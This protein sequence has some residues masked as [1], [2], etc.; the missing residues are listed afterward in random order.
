[1][2]IDRRRPPD[3]PPR[4]NA[5]HAV[6]AASTGSRSWRLAAATVAAFA[7]AAIV[8]ASTRPHAPPAEA[9]GATPRPTDEAR[10]PAPAAAV[11][12]DYAGLAGEAR[13]LGAWI[14]GHH[15]ERPQ[16]TALAA[17]IAAEE[18]DLDT[19]ATLWR[20]RLERAPEW[21]EGWYRLGLY[22]V[23][24]GRDAEAAEWLERA[25]RLDPSLPDIQGHL[26][27]CLLKADRVDEAAVVLAQAV[28]DDRGA[29]VRLFHLGHARL[30]QG[31]NDEAREAFQGAI[32][33]AP[34]YTGAWYGLATAAERLALPD[35]AE[36][37]RGEFRRLKHRDAEA[38][39][40]NASRDERARLRRLLA[41]WYAAAARIAA[42]DGAADEARALARRGAA[43]DQAPPAPGPAGEDR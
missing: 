2:P 42:L 16:S 21:A 23:K 13:T 27:R 32:D 9:P 5:R 25:R 24:E 8:V 17:A 12:E 1:M 20:A 29:A 33:R 14:V 3:R 6:G 18:G 41:G 26:G 37:A 39:A 10:F 36:R 22:A 11:P 28:G 4:K 30:R 7:L 35:E 43:I 15:P 34:A 31:R 19:A 40:D 38:A